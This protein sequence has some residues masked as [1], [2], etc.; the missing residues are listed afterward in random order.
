MK[1]TT[2]TASAS[3]MTEGKGDHKTLVV[4]YSATGNTERLAN[5][6]ATTLDADL[7]QLQPAQPYT[8]HDLDYNTPGTRATV[9]QKDEAARPQ[10]AGTL[11]DLKQYDTVYIGYPIWWGLAPRL[12]YT[13][14]EFADLTGKKVIPFCTSGGGGMGS[15]GEALAAAAKGK[16]NWVSGREFSPGATSA[17]LKAWAEKL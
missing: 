9:E 8:S 7:L 16:G 1:P 12:V 10:L 15:S 3:A 4:Y 13:F 5:T 11:P 17:Q 14:V 2:K 6:L